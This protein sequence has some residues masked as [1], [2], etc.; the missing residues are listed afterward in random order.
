MGDGG[1][2]AFALWVP[3]VCVGPQAFG[4]WSSGPGG[5]DG[6]WLAAVVAW[7][8]QGL[9]RLLGSAWVAWPGAGVRVGVF[10]AWADLVV[11]SV[12]VAGLCGWWDGAGWVSGMCAPKAWWVGLGHCGRCNGW[13]TCW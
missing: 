11:G 9:S 5:A 4:F 13:R 10:M 12:A 3:C 8:L 2:V 1:P 6:G 7:R